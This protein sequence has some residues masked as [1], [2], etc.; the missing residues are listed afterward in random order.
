MSMTKSTCFQKT[1]AVNSMEIKL[2]LKDGAGESQCMESTVQK[3]GLAQKAQ[4]QDPFPEW[5]E[6]EWSECST[7][8]CNANGIQT[9]EID[10]KVP[11]SKKFRTPEEIAA[12]LELC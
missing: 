4:C 3:W 1:C 12:D 2:T 5:I 10:C 11:D 6:G 7:I 9:R 8:Y